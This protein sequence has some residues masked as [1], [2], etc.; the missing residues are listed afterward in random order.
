MLPRKYT[1]I[2]LAS[3]YHP[4]GADNSSM[5]EYLITSL[6]IILRRDPECGIILTCDFNQLRDSFLRMH[7]GLE[8]LTKAATR[9]EAILDKIWTNV[10][11]VFDGVIGVTVLD[12]LGRSDHRMVLL[13]P[14]CYSTLDTGMLQRKVIRRSHTTATTKGHSLRQL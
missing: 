13:S 10:G 2:I 9:N 12:T 1:C 11:P 4:P 5:R 3:I 6:D 8:Q 14:A 7:Y